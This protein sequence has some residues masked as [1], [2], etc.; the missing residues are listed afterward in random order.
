MTTISAPG[1]DRRSTRPA[2]GGLRGVVARNP[3]RTFAVLA[4][5]TSWLVWLPYILS[6]HGL[7][8]WDLHFPEVLG[9]AQLSGVLPGALLGPV[10]AAFVVTAAVDGRTG[11]RVWTGRL[12]RWRVRWQWYVTVLLGVPVLIVLS[13]LPFAGG[14]VHAPSA[15]AL[16]AYVPALLLQVVTTGLAEEP[17]WRD[18]ALPRLQGRFGPMRA[19]LVLGP[20]WGLWHLPLFLTDWGGW[21]TAHWTQPVVF[22]GFCMA[23]TVVMSW[24]FNRSGESLP[25]AVLLHVS[26]NTTASVLWSDMFPGI[27][28]ETMLLALLIT[29]TIGAVVI[30]VAT[31][32]RLGYRG[33][34][35]GTAGRPGTG[36]AEDPASAVVA[37]TAPAAAPTPSASPLVDSSDGHR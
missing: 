24:V 33:P 29:S 18:F 37:G 32:G 21:P 15:L 13:G 6:P 3:L 20:L 16:A 34:V 17:G 28:A 10:T 12:W 8:I 1:T 35:A 23:F 14:V 19:A 25:L 4:L 30:V 2:P 9:T 31:R 5:G 11:L 36:P 22:V 7:G 27:G 26:V